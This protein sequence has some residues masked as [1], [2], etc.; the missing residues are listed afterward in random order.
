MKRVIALSV[1]AVVC[2]TP[3]R[4]SANEP[5]LVWTSDAG[6]H[7]YFRHSF[8]NASGSGFSRMI[9]PPMV[10]TDFMWLDLGDRTYKLGTLELVGIAKHETPVVFV[11]LLHRISPLLR[12]TRALTALEHEAIAALRDGDDVIVDE[13]AKR[14]LIV[15]ALR[16]EAACLQCHTDYRVGDLLGALSYRLDRAKLP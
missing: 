4:T 11:D 1:I 9:A 16:A 13:T 5:H 3:A 14:R 12:Q 2:L 10:V 15:G 6:M 7:N 8:L